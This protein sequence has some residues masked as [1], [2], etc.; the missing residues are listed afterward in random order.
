MKIGIA[1]TRPI[2]GDIS[3]NIE[4][5]CQLIKL[6]L[7]AGADS[8][9][10]PELS[11]T[12]YEPNLADGLA[13]DANDHQLESFQKIS[14]SQQ[15]T[16]G[17]GIPV[18]KSN[19]IGI[20]MVIFQ[21]HQARQLYSKKYLHSD[22]DAFF[23]SGDEQP[24]LTGQNSNIGLAICYEISIPSHP[25]AA[26][27][28]GATYYIA[29]LAKSLT[30]TEKALSTLSEIA[31]SYSMTTFMAN[32]IGPSDDFTGGGKSSIWNSNGD[33]LGQLEKD[34]EGLLVLDSDTRKVERIDFPSN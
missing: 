13:M 29:C 4:A 27:R 22:E 26:C 30:G 34:K 10:F 24:L 17:V 7:K 32:S 33:L 6:A 3:A 8:I 28:G 9:F 5:H 2:K 1:Q 12:G 14:N 11:L 19:G 15:L 25:A 18:R 16:I 20:G 23:V 21:P 31:H